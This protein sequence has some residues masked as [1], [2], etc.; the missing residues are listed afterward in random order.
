MKISPQAIRNGTSTIGA[1]QFDGAGGTLL[2][3]PQGQLDDA[4]EYGD[5]I[6]SSKNGSPVY[7]RDVAKAK[8]SVQ[9]ERINMRFWVRG[10]D[11]PAATV[12][13]AVNRKAGANAVEVAQSVRRACCR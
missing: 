3:R 10:Y 11:P 5:L 12:I 4:K 8:N 7:L 1:G 9:D 2:L 13:V 6:V